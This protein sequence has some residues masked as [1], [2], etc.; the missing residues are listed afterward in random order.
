VKALHVTPNVRPRRAISSYIFCMSSSQLGWNL[1]LGACAL[2]VAACGSDGGGEHKGGA[3]GGVAECAAP[4]S[5]T[6][7]QLGQTTN[8]LDLLFVI[9]DSGSMREEQAKLERELPRLVNILTTGDLNQDGDAT[10][11]D[12]F[13]PISS[14]HLGVVSS[15]MGT[16][17]QLDDVVAACRGSGDDGVLL[18]KVSRAQA[19]NPACADVAV[20]GY[21]Q[22]KTDGV[23][24]VAAEADKV[25]N[26]FGCVATLGTGGCGLEQQLEAM[27]KALTPQGSESVTFAVGR[28]HGDEKNAGFLRPEA[29]LG[30]IQVSDEEDCSVTEKG[31]VLFHNP[32]ADA[33]DAYDGPSDE[34]DQGD[35]VGLNFQ[36]ANAHDNPDD[37]DDLL[38][39]AQRFID[40]LK[41]LKPD[42]P[43]RIVFT[44]I[45][46][47]PEA[48]ATMMNDEVQDFDA[49]LGMND[50][51]VFPGTRNEN[52]PN[53]QCTR[54]QRQADPA[55]CGPVSLEIL[56]RPACAGND[57][58][59]S[60]AS[61]ARRFVE[62]AKGFQENGLVRSICSDSYAGAFGDFLAKV[63]KKSR[64]RFCLPSSATPSAFDVL[65]TLPAGVNLCDAS[66]GRVL[67]GTREVAGQRR[68]VCKINEVGVHDGELVASPD[69]ADGVNP[70]VGW[71][72]DDFSDEVRHCA[73]GLRVAFTAGAEPVETAALSLLAD[74]EPQPDITE[75]VIDLPE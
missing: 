28:G 67:L 2:G 58:M 31:K 40:G 41:A 52:D 43:D 26:D 64:D 60:W 75:C 32:S 38:Q 72:R 11:E 65:E 12:D 35:F 30:V 71:Y 53:R 39:P 7:A 69:A 27:L 25:A 4:P 22:F 55:G 73:G 61:P 50:M 47:V 48:A 70:L 56:P 46:G 34:V 3:D 19:A 74:G 15:N 68:T 20:D 33:H 54:E 10:D 1:V 36:C 23:D 59:D 45:V 66:R 24:D 37:P 8:E 16:L 51:Q 13:E 62:V 18:D 63:G 44:A 17:G 21:M 9:D 5:A 42:N 29:T 49:I 57:G 14:L 6:L